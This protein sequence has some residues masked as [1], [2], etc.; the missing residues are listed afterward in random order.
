MNVGSVRDVISTLE[1]G[2]RQR[3]YQSYYMTKTPAAYY[4][5]LETGLGHSASSVKRSLDFPNI[6][7]EPLP[8]ASEDWEDMFRRLW[9]NDGGRGGQP[10]WMNS[11]PFV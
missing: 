3:G 7:V 6:R 5:I 1:F 8:Y 4:I 10:F 9:I 2:C 11:G